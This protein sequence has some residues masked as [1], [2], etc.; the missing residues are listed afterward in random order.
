[1]KRKGFTLIE[2]LAVIVILGI[3]ALIVMPVISN[4]IESSRKAV[5]RESVNNI[6]DA[7]RNYAG[8]YMLAHG[9]D[10]ITY[11]VEFICDGIE[12]TDGVYP[13]EVNGKIP[14]GGKIYLYQDGRMYADYVTDGMYCAVGYKGELRVSNDCNDLDITSPVVHHEKESDI[15]IRTTSNS[16]IVSVPNDLMEDEETDISGYKVRVYEGTTIIDTKE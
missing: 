7:S 4:V 12:C 10:D 3:I 2:L 5:F 16:I 14:T 6:M 8:T 11:P 15:I 13:I 1:M 9:K